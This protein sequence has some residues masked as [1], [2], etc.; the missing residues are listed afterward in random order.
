MSLCLLSR[1]NLHLFGQPL[2]VARFLLCRSSLD[3]GLHNVKQG[4]MRVTAVAFVLLAA[5][6]TLAAG[7]ATPP[8][9]AAPPIPPKPA[10]GSAWS[11]MMGKKKEG[12]GGLKDTINKNMGKTGGAMGDAAAKAKGNI[13]DKFKNP[14]AKMG[15]KAYDKVAAAA[16]D[17][18]AKL[19]DKATKTADAAKET[20]KSNGW[21]WGKKSGANSMFGNLRKKLAE[22]GKK[23]KNARGDGACV[24]H[25]LS[26]CLY[27]AFT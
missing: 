26:V 21:G 10:A 8:S 18:H 1:G 5:M 25:G 9:G 13:F 19:Q 12:F 14:F 11:K 2:S 24:P 23:F 16:G 4:K 27:F 20:A 6:A 15:T 22:Q 7:P 17:I 3:L